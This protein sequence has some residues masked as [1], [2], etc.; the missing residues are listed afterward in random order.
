MLGAGKV[1]QEVACKAIYSGRCYVK[2]STTLGL[3]AIALAQSESGFSCTAANG[4]VGESSLVFR[5]VI[6]HT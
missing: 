5:R 2:E 1:K 6:S 4:A 3:P